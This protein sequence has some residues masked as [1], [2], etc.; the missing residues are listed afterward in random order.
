MNK[1]E[2]IYEGKAK[3]VFT[4]DNNQVVLI[5][6][7]DDATAFNGEKRGTIEDKGIVNNRITCMLYKH[8]EKE[9]VKTHLVEQ[10]D[11]RSAL[12]KKL[13]MIPVEVVVRNIVAGS[14]AKLVEKPEGTELPCTIL[15]FYYKNDALNDPMINEYHIKAM[16]WVTE[17]QLLEMKTTALKIN[18]ILQGLFDKI[19]I[20]LVDFKLEFGLFDNQVILGDE[21]SPD[22]CRLWDKE[23]LEKLDKDR[24]R[25]NLGQEK[26]AYLEVV[27][28]LES[29]L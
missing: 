15:E 21:I 3:Q 22:T 26:E 7:K 14:L 27:K 13:Q 6:Y 23:S 9:G 20:I 29:I 16:N 28:R 12:V 8:L 24:F 5:Y 11:E 1:G 17:E 18:D 10:V 2:M 19:G 25:R 4:T